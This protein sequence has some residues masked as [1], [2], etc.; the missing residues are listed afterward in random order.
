MSDLIF[1]GD[2]LRRVLNTAAARMK[3][4]VFAKDEGVYL[5]IADR[6]GKVEHI[7]YADGHDP[8][9]AKTPEER[10]ALF[11]RGQ[12]A[13]GGDDFS[14]PI[15]FPDDMRE[16]LNVDLSTYLRLILEPEKVVL[17]VMVVEH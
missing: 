3:P 14:E 9:Q 1:R 4:I 15:C 11:D 10:V 6:Q 5:Y 13:C 7:C 2:A 16:A 12:E 8:T 17:M